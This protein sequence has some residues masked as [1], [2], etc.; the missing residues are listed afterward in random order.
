VIATTR[1]TKTTDRP[2]MADLSEEKNAR[3]SGQS[4]RVLE[5]NDSVGSVDLRGPVER[6]TARRVLTFLP[7]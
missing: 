2:T 1:A 3:C 5:P 7:A 6:L 4:V